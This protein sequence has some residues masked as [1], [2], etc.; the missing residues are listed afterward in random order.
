LHVSINVAPVILSGNKDGRNLI[1]DGQRIVDIDTNKVVYP[2]LEGNCE[3][4]YGAVDGSLWFD[5]SH[6]LVHI[7]HGEME[8]L[9]L[10]AAIPY[11]HILAMTEDEQRHL[12]IAPLRSQIYAHIN[13]A[14]VEGSSLGL[15]SA[16]A[17][18]AFRQSSGAAWFGFLDGRVARLAREHADIFGEQQGL[19]LGLVSVFDEVQGK[20][21]VGGAL[22]VAVL[23]RNHFFPMTLANGKGLRGVTGIAIQPSGTLWLNSSAGVISIKAA[24]FTAFLAN[25]SYQVPYE[26]YGASDG[27][28][29][30]TEAIVGLGSA[31][32]G[33]NGVLYIVNRTHFQVTNPDQPRRLPTAPA[34]LITTLSDGHTTMQEPTGKFTTTVNPERVEV[35]FTSTSLSMPDIVSFRYRLQGYDKGWNSSGAQHEA[36]YTRLPPGRYT[37]I[38]DAT[39]SPTLWPEAARRSITIIVPPTFTQTASF[40]ALTIVCVLAG[41]LLAL[42]VRVDMAKNNLRRLFEARATERERIARE[43]HDNF[44]PGVEA[45]LLHVHAVT[46]KLFKQGQELDPL[47]NAFEQADA[48]MS[49][50]RTLVYGLRHA[51]DDLPFEE[52]L[53]SF[54]ETMNPLDKP[55][56]SISSRDVKRQ[57][58]PAAV[59]E[60]LSI[61]K[62]GIWNA[63]RH[64]DA[65]RIEVSMA[66]RARDILLLIDDDGLGIRAEDIAKSPREGHFGLQGMRERASKLKA[67]LHIGKSPLGGTRVSLEVPNSV[68]YMSAIESLSLR[69]SELVV[70]GKR[71]L[72]WLNQSK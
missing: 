16:M 23:Q 48:V 37:L 18:V 51:E 34:V 9:P 40:R 6:Q 15:P 42:L 64:A 59:S 27:V 33:T 26:L 31:W 66:A 52:S 2:K 56:V 50:G 44:F 30:T 12:L 68:A 47:T 4:A 10:P 53:R 19:R 28:E 39:N 35:Q 46:S 5:D 32:I 11:K 24:D 70:R 1:C 17:L 8:K 72:V 60:I 41:I 62:E 69:W 21:L 14:W 55:S 7:I 49:Q 57:L 22:G 25:P 13:G 58:D 43:L 54:A 61:A 67:L 45:L 65:T 29:G 20:I 36:V 71:S 38:I 3:T 63:I